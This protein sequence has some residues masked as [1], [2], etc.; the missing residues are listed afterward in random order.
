MTDAG[1]WVWVDGAGAGP[2]ISASEMQRYGLTVVDL[3]GNRVALV[4][5]ARHRTGGVE[6][7]ASPCVHNSSKIE[8][9]RPAVTSN[10]LLDEAPV[11]ATFVIWG[12]KIEQVVA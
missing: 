5:R 7:E 10:V 3:L 4:V 2:W 6:V 11:T 9:Y 1:K 8:E 12:G